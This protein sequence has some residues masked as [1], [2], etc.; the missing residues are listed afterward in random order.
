MGAA[1]SFGLLAAWQPACR[2]NT[3]YPLE[4]NIRLLLPLLHRRPP[5]VRWFAR[6]V[7]L[8][9]PVG[10]VP[11]RSVGGSASQPASRLSEPASERASERTKPIVLA[12]VWLRTAPV[13]LTDSKADA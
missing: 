2:A 4:L 1:R 7:G 6:S 13:L 10:T 3:S 11:A 12:L 8:S 9:W 5:L